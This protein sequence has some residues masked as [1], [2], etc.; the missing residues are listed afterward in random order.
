MSTN[1]NSASET[2]VPE[3]DEKTEEF[4]RR[5]N[6][7]S[8]N[9]SPGE[10]IL[11]VTSDHFLE[12]LPKLIGPI[13]VVVVSLAMVLYRGVGGQFFSQGLPS[14]TPLDAANL[15]LIVLLIATVLA[16]LRKPAK[17]AKG[18]SYRTLILGAAVL[19]GLLIHFR[20]QGGRLFYIDPTQALAPADWLLE[21]INM[22]FA[23]IAV[24]GAA[25]A[26]YIHQESENDHLIVTNRRVIL[27]DR[28]LL[29]KQQLDQV[30]LEDVQNVAARSDTY[31]QHWLKFGKVVVTSTR[32]QLE[33]PGA[34]RPMA[35]QK[36]IMDQV[37]SLRG[38]E[39]DVK[40]RDMINTGVYGASSTIPRPEP[41]L[42]IS[43][44]P[45]ILQWI[46]PENPTID[47]KGTIT[48]R[49]HWLFLFIGLVNPVLFAFLSFL[50]ILVGANFG[51]LTGLLTG[52]LAVG[53]VFAFIIWSWY[54]IEDYRNDMY[55]LTRTNIIDIEQRPFGP[56]DRRTAS[57]GAVQ[58]VTSKTSLVS[59][60]LGYGDVFLETAG[61]GAFTFH[62]VPLPAQVVKMIN[63]YQDDFRRGEK[64]RTLQDVIKLIK[65]YHTETD[66]RRREETSAS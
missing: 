7:Y 16:W 9:L 18:N 38:Q 32:K 43:T 2:S 66:R 52:A 44:H 17:A 45:R 22:I 11:D 65:Y 5:Y 37:N 56:E 14:E 4:L 48:W 64:D 13:L 35:L 49:P 30:A 1:Q 40:F 21:P 53:V 55:I 31:V 57:L 10:C 34:E 23:V 20:I 41:S 42:R 3:V 58:N 27:F 54:N 12:V 63:T 33:F 15:A 29:G 50:A 6:L 39:T 62:R 8:I 60:Q 51:A 46:V 24:I 25:F 26:V 47:A 61:A 28:Q 36:I 19:I 59:R